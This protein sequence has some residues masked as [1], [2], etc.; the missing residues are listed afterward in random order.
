MFKKMQLICVVGLLLLLAGCGVDKGKQIQVEGVDIRSV[1]FVLY[2][3]CWCV[4]MVETVRQ[5]KRVR[6]DI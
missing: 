4:I 5:M 1:A 6:I 2:N 3:L